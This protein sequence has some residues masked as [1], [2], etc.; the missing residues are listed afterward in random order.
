MRVG[1][2][3][4]WVGAVGRKKPVG[5]WEGGRARVWVDGWV[6][7]C[8][9]GWDGGGGGGGAV[10]ELRTHSDHRHASQHTVTAHGG[11]GALGGHQHACA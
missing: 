5:G 10:Q 6:K 4:G 1:G 8:T 2:E 9:E 3:R 11:L 7:R